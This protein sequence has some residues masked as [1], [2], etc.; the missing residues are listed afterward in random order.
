MKIIQTPLTIKL[1]IPLVKKIV[2]IP[3]ENI[4]YCQS[5]DNYS[6]IYTTDNN[7]LLVSKTLKHMQE[8]LCD[9]GFIRCHKS[10]LVNLSFI[11]EFD[12]AKN[13]CLKL[14]NEQIIPITKTGNTCIRNLLK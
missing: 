9:F 11:C 6:Q 2:F 7:K 13:H 5:I 10:Y 12:T 1:A 8:L 3:V 4:I 14:T